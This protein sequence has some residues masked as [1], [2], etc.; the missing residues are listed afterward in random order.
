MAL[1]GDTIKIK[2]RVSDFDG[3][4]VDSVDSH[5]IKVYDSGDTLKTTVSSV[6]WDESG[7]FFINYI[8]PSDGKPGNWTAVWKIIKGALP[9]IEKTQF[10]VEEVP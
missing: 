2:N 3:S 7:F 1:V 9:S 4:L 10:E 8:I 5:E 6:E